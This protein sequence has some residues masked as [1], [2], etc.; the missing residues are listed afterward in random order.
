VRSYKRG[1]DPLARAIALG[2]L[3]VI[4]AFAFHMFFDDLFVH[5]MEVQIALVMVLVSVSAYMKSESTPPEA[6]PQ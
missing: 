3:G 5:G 1:T 4:V 2:G 6:I